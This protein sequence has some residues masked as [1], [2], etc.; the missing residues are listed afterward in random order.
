MSNRIIKKIT[1]CSRATAYLT[2]GIIGLGFA[3]ESFSKDSKFVDIRILETNKL[4]AK[5]LD[6]IEGR[7]KKIPDFSNHTQRIYR[8]VEWG[9]G[10]NHKVLI[11]A[12]SGPGGGTVGCGFYE[13]DT[14]GNFVFLIGQP[15]CKFTKKP[16]IYIR[17][18]IQIIRFGISDRQYFG[19]PIFNESYKFIF[20]SEMNFFCH[21]DSE[22]EIF[23]CPAY[24]NKFQSED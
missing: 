12:R 14:D 23:K 21:P 10:S 2:M 4:D 5:S 16:D 13:Q 18:G 7:L 3:F 15:Y 20:N 22:S 1:M 19:G 11:A 24:L 9:S 6:E 8:V 17:E